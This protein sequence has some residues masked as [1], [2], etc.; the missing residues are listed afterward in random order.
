MS[1]K[2]IEYYPLQSVGKT[3]TTNGRGTIV[4]GFEKKK[5]NTRI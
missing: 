4:Y 1:L 5:Q 3:I 2:R